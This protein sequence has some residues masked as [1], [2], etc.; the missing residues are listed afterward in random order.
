MGFRIWGLG[1][2][3]QGFGGKGLYRSYIG[4]MENEIETATIRS[5]RV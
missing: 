3:V 5:C 2:R 1:F 4:I